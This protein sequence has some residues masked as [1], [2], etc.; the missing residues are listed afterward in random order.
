LY[1]TGLTRTLYNHFSTSFESFNSSSN[2]PSKAY[3]YVD[4]NGFK[5]LTD[6]DQLNEDANKVFAL[7]TNQE[8][9]IE[10]LCLFEN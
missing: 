10:A 4:A 6:V 3:V 5:L 9:G 8:G 1:K 7:A 2:D